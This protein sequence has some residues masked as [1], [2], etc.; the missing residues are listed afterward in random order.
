LG[1]VEQIRIFALAEILRLKKFGQ[2]NNVRTA[3]RGLVDLVDG[4]LQILIRLGRGGHLDEPDV[5]FL[6]WQP[7]LPKEKTKMKE[8]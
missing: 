1:Q 2:A 4:S 8:K 5:E 7:S 3:C 6:R